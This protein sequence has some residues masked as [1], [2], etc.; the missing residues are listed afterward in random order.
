MK[1]IDIT[2][3]ESHEIQDDRQK[4]EKVKIESGY[5]ACVVTQHKWKDWIEAD[6]VSLINTCGN[7]STFTF[8]S[9]GA[10]PSVLL[11]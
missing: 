6:Y 2:T 5:L 8:D 1:I 4:A 9:Q 7:L 10:G 3:C 11:G